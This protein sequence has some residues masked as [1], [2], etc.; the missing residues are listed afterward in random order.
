LTTESLTEFMFGCTC[1]RNYERSR[2]NVNRSV[3]SK[4]CR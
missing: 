1:S 2:G 4:F 3:L